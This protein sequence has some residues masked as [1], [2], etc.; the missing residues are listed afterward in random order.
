[1]ERVD[2]YAKE[3]QRYWT[4]RAPSYSQVNREELATDQRQVWSRTLDEG[5]RGCFPRRSRE[6]IRVLDVGTGPGF[7]AILLTELGY[8]VTAVDY[9]P[10][11]L[12]Q[13]EENA[14][15]LGAN[16]SFY[17]MDAQNL[18]FPD[19]TFDVV[20]SRNLTWNLPQPQRAY[21]QWVRVLRPGGMLL[22]FDANWYRYLFDPQAQQGHLQDRENVQRLHAADDTAGTDVAAM[23]AIARQ[24]PLSAQRRPAWD[25]EVLTALGLEAEADEQVWRQ[26]W[27]RDEWLNNASTPMFMVRAVKAAPGEAGT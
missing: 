17:T 26:V 3:N 21:A 23:E 2:I 1:M 4:Q 24:A 9:T 15:A 7:F 12:A 14:G 8:A 6:E 13:A 11:M 19:H 10:A 27:T 25:L 20:V 22:N 18:T 16:I 5:I